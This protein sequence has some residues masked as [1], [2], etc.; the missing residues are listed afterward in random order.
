MVEPAV[1]QCVALEFAKQHI[2][3]NTISPAAID[4]DMIDRFAGKEG[5]PEMP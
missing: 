2:R 3:V 5:R 4:T 1:E